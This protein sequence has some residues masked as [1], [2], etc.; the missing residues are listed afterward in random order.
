MG[1]LVAI[2]IPIFTSQLEKSREAVDEV[3]LRSAYAE[4]A[5]AVLTETANTTTADGVT[6][7]VS[8]DV[9]TAT[10][11]VTTA[12]AVAGWT[13]DKPDVGELKLTDAEAPVKGTVAVT[14]SSNGEIKIGTVSSTTK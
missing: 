6:I 1:V 9:V 4:C 7:T 10:K 12:Q 11:S 13:G 14:A 5:A 2:L 3:K 8:D